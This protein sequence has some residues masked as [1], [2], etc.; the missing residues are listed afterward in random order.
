MQ[1]YMT[2]I[3][4]TALAGLVGTLLVG[5][6]RHN[7]VG[8]PNYDRKPL[9]NWGRLGVYYVLMIIVLFAILFYAIAE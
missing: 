8:D 3:I 2:L 7:K 4:L 1:I 5:F 6:S 9:G